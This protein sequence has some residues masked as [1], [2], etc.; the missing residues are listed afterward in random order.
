MNIRFYNARI[1]TMEGDLEIMEGELW[2]KGNRIVYVGDGSD[3]DK[4]YRDDPEGMI[5]WDREID[6]KRNLLMPGFK[7]AHT[8]TAMTFLRSYAD[9]LPLDEWLNTQVFPK[10]ALLTPEDIYTLTK[11]GIMEYLSSGITAGFDM[12]M[13][14]SMIA[15]AA[16]ETGFRMV[17]VGSINNFGGTVEDCEEEYKYLNSLGELSSYVFGFHAEYT[18]SREIMEGIADLSKKY[19]V[20]V[21]THSSETSKE[22]EGCKKR[23]GMTPTKLFDSMGMYDNGGGGYHCVWMSDEDLEIFRDKKLSVVTNPASNAKLASGIAPITKMMDM[24][25]NIAIGTDGAASNNALDMFR[26]MYLVT[27][28]AKLR[29][30][31][32]A[33]VDGAEVLKMATVGGAKAMC[34]DDCDVLAPGK[35]ADIVMIDMTQPNMQPE[36][37]IVKNI[38]YAGS[39]SNVKM[40]MVN[41]RVLYEDGKYDI[42]ISP[43]ELNGQANA[44]IQRMI[45]DSR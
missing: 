38:V 23:Y 30:M 34:L 20:P 29:E 8:H 31:D 41:G 14:T 21:F 37:N 2:V 12:Y 17:Q 15:K 24:G 4:I 1:L 3:T 39:K 7:D 6:V 11:H 18:T 42:G 33:V 13:Q 32:A 9:D 16:I 35:Y 45:R 44:I 25:I 26:E 40:T 5:I 19:K 43:E 10:E 28:L 36:N 22:V 27:A